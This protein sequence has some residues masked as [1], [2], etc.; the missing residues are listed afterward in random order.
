MTDKDP[1]LDRP[2]RVHI[3]GHVVVYPWQ[4]NALHLVTLLTA[5]A[6][7]LGLHVFK[8]PLKPPDDP[9]MAVVRRRWTDR[10]VT[11]DE[12]Y[13]FIAAR[14]GVRF[15]AIADSL[16]RE[17]AYPWTVREQKNAEGKLRTSLS[18]LRSDGK[19][20]KCIDTAG[21]ECWTPTG[22]EQGLLV[23]RHGRAPTTAARIAAG[24]AILSH[25]IP[26]DTDDPSMLEDLARAVFNA[27]SEENADEGKERDPN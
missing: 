2:I 8:S 13:R 21:N 4:D 18:R 12:I 10:R 17:P 7:Q 16:F 27:M 5:A 3:E 15:S 22:P 19:I 9:L 11:T 23:T 25:V 20:I 6:T 14:P 1:I 26:P 24:A